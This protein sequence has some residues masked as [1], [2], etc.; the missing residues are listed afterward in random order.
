MSR[1]A[2]ALLLSGV[3]LGCSVAVAQPD[4]PRPNRVE[5]FTGEVLIDTKGY[6]VV[7]LVDT[8]SGGRDGLV[9]QWFILTSTDIP[10]TL[11][12][13]LKAAQILHSDGHLRVVSMDRRV[14]YDFVLADQP[15]Q[16]D[17]PTGFTAT[18]I[19]GYGL[20]H[21]L[22]ETTIRIP[23]VRRG[24]VTTADCEGCDVVY[25]CDGCDGGGT[26]ASSCESGGQGAT[27]CSITNGS[28]SCSITCTSSYRA[29]CNTTA[30]G[31]SCKCVLS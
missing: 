31:V 16:A 15:R 20:S 12:E 23:Q 22:G 6:H 7:V 2:Y 9:D 10:P 8:S 17:L 4:P 14:A 28:K 19:E 30:T 29:C 13:H 24:W 11:F 3:L 18:H 21:N 25:P 27:S 1:A 5:S 26:G